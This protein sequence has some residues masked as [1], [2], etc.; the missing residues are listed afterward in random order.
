MLFTWAHPRLAV[1]NTVKIIILPVNYGPFYL[2]L[3]VK[4]TCVYKTLQY[5]DLHGAINQPPSSRRIR[6]RRRILDAHDISFIR[7]LVSLNRTAYVD[8]IQEQLLTRRG[9]QVS[10]MTLVRTLR[11]LR[12]T[13][14]TTS[15]GAL[16]RNDTLR[17]LYMNRIGDLITDPNQL[18]FGD[19]AS[20]DEHTSV[21]RKGWSEKGQRCVQRKFFVRGIRYSI[22]PI[23]SLDG[24]ITYD[25]IEGS[26]TTAKFIKFLKDLVV[27]IS[28]SVS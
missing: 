3:G 6:G 4:K 19:E 5:Y 16:E 7:S 10:I 8:E 23:L 13:N 27:C 1:H 12:M 21:R 11:R 28:G 18:M 20:K 2:D 17:A 25:I 14:K 9:T 15:G 24:I 26:V 22:L